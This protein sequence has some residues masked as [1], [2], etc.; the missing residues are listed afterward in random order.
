VEA[1][2]LQGA[3]T[4]FIDFDEKA[5]EAHALAV[6]KHAQHAPAFEVCDVRDISALERAI[7]SLAKTTG[8]FEVLVNNA[9]SDD[10]MSLD[11]M[12]IEN[13][14]N[15]QAVNLRHV[16]FAS[17]AVFA[18]MRTAGFGS[19]INFSS[20]TFRRRTANT[21]GYATAKSAIEG[22]SRV[23]SR[24]MGEAGIRVNTV[25]PGWTLTERQRAL[26]L[27]PEADKLL[28]ETQCLKTHV[29]P[30]DIA[31]MVLFLA[32]DD[33]RAITAQVF[34]VDGGLV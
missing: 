9:A 4:A 2:A 29:M 6:A 10:R 34:I 26:W 7:S 3:R 23:M 33:S 20:P 25:M 12:T 13:W 27:T 5:G 21:S 11:D 17:K 28:M 19:I 32:S 14:D 18:D 30:A 15:F 16:A 8:P 24:E 31:R 1:F 22:L